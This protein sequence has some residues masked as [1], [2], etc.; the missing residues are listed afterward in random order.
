MQNEE[1]KF[2]IVLLGDSNVGKSSFFKGMRNIFN[3]EVTPTVGVDF[4]NYKE[5]INNKEMNIM[6]WDTAGQE[7]FRSII[8]SYFRECAGYILLFDVN[9]LE[10]LFNLEYWIRDIK[11]Q[12]VCEH[13]HPLLILGNKTDL[14]YNNN[15]DENIKIE[16]QNIKDYIDEM[17]NKKLN[18]DYYFKEISI[19][20][21][22]NQD[23]KKILND[24]FMKIYKSQN[25]K[26]CK[27]VKMNKNSN[28]VRNSILLCSYS[29]ND[30][31][32]LNL[33]K[34]C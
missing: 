17:F 13:K 22:T 5:I 30:Q 26:N 31:P 21:C 32:L 23:I 11:S 34:C 6:M 9:N 8:K 1:V 33:E 19:L 2:K 4:F 15:S 28:N 3:E 27:F 20:S 18:E 24:F 16:K 25:E 12:N 7:K 10:S 29:S 14:R